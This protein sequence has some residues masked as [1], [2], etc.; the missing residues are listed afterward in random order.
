MKKSA[1]TIFL[2]LLVFIGFAQDIRFS[3]SG[4]YNRHIKKAEL[5]DIKTMADIQ[6]D[7][8]KNW[9]SDYKYVIV[10]GTVNGNY[11]VAASVNDVLNTAQLDILYN[12]DLGSDLEFEIKYLNTN[13]VTE[14]KD[15]M[16]MNYKLTVVSDIEAEFKNGMG[17]LTKYLL[18]NAI[19]KIPRAK[20]ESLGN[21]LV[22][23]TVNEAGGIS[24]ITIKT[25]SGDTEI[26]Q[27][28]IKVIAEMPAWSPAQDGKGNKIKQ[29]F[30][31]TIGNQNGC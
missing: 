12:A 17:G 23:F 28:L 31:F 21:G 2:S 22:N 18:E 24:D 19:N 16:W 1:F 6:K 29:V 5:H 25:T 30:Q 14:K 9:I 15:N 4:M 27:M 20:K 7:Y 13:A 3:V 8:P 10:A 11:K 26:D